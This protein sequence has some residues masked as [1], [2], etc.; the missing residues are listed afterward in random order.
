MKIDRSQRNA[1]LE[2]YQRYAQ[3]HELRRSSERQTIVDGCLINY[4]RNN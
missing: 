2:R 3:Q 1:A 4:Y